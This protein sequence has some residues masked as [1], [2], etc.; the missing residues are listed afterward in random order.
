MGLAMIVPSRLMVDLQLCV[1]YEIFPEDIT[2]KVFTKSLF[3]G[4][5]VDNECNTEDFRLF[6]ALGYDPVLIIEKVSWLSRRALTPNVFFLGNRPLMMLVILEMG[7]ADG[8]LESDRQVLDR[9]LHSACRTK[10]WQVAQKLLQL[11]AQPP[12]SM[13]AEQITTMVEET[14]L[15]ES[16]D[17]FHSCVYTIRTGVINQES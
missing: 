10:Q 13:S 16:R 5:T 8:L 11:G 7:F 2:V 3:A 14:V 1:E 9:L 12:Q 4:L 15:M 6:L 17:Q